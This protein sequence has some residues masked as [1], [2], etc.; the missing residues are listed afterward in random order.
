MTSSSCRNRGYLWDQSDSDDNDD[1]F[2]SKNDF[3]YSES[4]KSS[5]KP[6]SYTITPIASGHTADTTIFKSAKV[7]EPKNSRQRRFVG[8]V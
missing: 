5:K 1:D 2:F 8:V 6:P 3:S 4:T 7:D